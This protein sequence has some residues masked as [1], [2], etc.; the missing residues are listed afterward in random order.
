MSGD[1]AACSKYLLTSISSYDRVV[2]KLAKWAALKSTSRCVYT[3][4]TD[5]WTWNRE[6]MSVEGDGHILGPV[7]RQQRGRRADNGDQPTSISVAV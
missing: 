5:D 1:F 2:V 6:D 4:L 3:Q 7:P